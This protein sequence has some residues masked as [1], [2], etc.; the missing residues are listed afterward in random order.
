MP[1][2]FSITDKNKW[3]E[4]Y[5]SGRSEFS[6]ASDSRCDLRT[7][8][9]GIEEAR[10]GRDAQAARIDLL[11]RAVLKHQES[12]MNK[13]EEFLS[14]LTMP[15]HD[16]AVL[17]WVENGQFI[18]SESDLDMDDVVED[19]MSD[20]LKKSDVQADM[21]EDMLRQHLRGDKLWK[22]LARREKA[23]SLHRLARIALQYKVVGL[24]EEKTGYKLEARG[25]VPPP[26]LYA[27]TT[28]D[29][30]Y[31][32][33][34]ADAFGDSKNDTW[35]DE[36]VADTSAGCVKYRN[37]ILAE[38]PGKADK[39][40]K[41]LLDAFRKMQLLAEVTRVVDT[42]KELEESTFKAKQAVEE[43][44]LLGLVPGVCKTCRRLGM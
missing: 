8:R 39:C 37:M 41:N 15:P 2:K 21:V 38:V 19:E 1:K 35:Q 29:L 25:D 7:V 27:Y 26:F 34:L 13:L 12:L 23:Y 16:W 42:Y 30:L 18:L 44:R 31:R 17:S 9:R 22:I 4:D 24:L 20:G 40:R 3:L 43:I 36:I 14:T 11:K 5:E 6:I 10:R 32:M 28:G 33:T